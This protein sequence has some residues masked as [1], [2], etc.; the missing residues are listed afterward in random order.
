MAK[1]VSRRRTT[2]LSISLTPELAAEIAERVRSGL[3][4]SAS[5][6]LRE[7]LRLF[8]KVEAL[9]QERTAAGTEREQSPAARRLASA[10]ELFDLGRALDR[11]E[12]EARPRQGEEELETG[13]GLRLAPE[14]LERLTLRE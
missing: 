12:A 10:L 3:Y 6:L 11:A 14:R 4:T 7:A 8:L 9:H 13:P 5:E 1:P 2:T